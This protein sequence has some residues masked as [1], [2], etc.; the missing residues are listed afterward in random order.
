[1]D[2]QRSLDEHAIHIRSRKHSESPRAS[3]IE[4]KLR[5]PSCE[6]HNRQ[7]AVL[8]KLP[9]SR[10]EKGIVP[11]TEPS[12]IRPRAALDISRGKSTSLTKAAQLVRRPAKKR[13]SLIWSHWWLWE[14]LAGLLMLVMF[15]MIVTILS[16]YDSQPLPNWPHHIEINSLMSVFATLLRSSMLLILSESKRILASNGVDVLIVCFRYW[17]TQVDMVSAAASIERS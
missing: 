9:A 12:V 5:N 3:L 10:R 2:D 17:P 1:M 6:S 13:C 16:K 7:S 15:I 4:P 8:D 11:V 14:I